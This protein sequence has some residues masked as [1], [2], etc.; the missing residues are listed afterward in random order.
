MRILEVEAAAREAWEA[1]SV[2]DRVDS[3][4]L[5]L[6]EQPGAGTL[7]RS[8]SWRTRYRNAAIASDVACALAITLAV[9]YYATGHM[10]LVAVI[11]VLAF[12]GTVALTGGYTVRHIWM[13]RREYRSIALGLVS[14]IA[15]AMVVS[16]LGVAPMPP[17]PVTLGAVGIAMS[18]GLLRTAQR[19]ILV[20]RRARGAHRSRAILVGPIEHTERMRRTVRAVRGVDLVGVC[21]PDRE[22]GTELA[23]GVPVLGTARE[24]TSLAESLGADV[25]MVSAG[26]MSPDEF[27]QFRWTME[28][29]G[30]EVVVV[31][32]VD[33][34]LG[35]RIDLQVID[36]TPM[37]TLTGPTGSQHVAK[38]MM[39]RVL[40]SLLLI[41]FGPVILAGAAAVKLTSAGPAIF[42][43]IRVGRD[44]R[45][46]TMLK[47]R[48]MRVD[49]ED[50]RATLLDR[51]EGAG[52]L[53]KM[54][55]DPRITRVGR[56]LRRFSLDE[57]PQLWNV[58]RGDMSLVGPRPPLQSEVATYDAMAVH[59]LHVRPGLT[60]LWQVS[61]RSDLTWEE[62]IRLDLRYVDNWSLLFDLQILWRTV[63]AVVG[64]HGAY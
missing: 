48:S 26:I 16:F 23:T 45:P 25:V 15:V 22:P 21:V 42:R 37:M 47:L 7:P 33:E 14:L 31:P 58:V 64:A 39:D 19:N 36:A 30:T 12:V 20:L 44:G 27:R 32:E 8:H 34:V 60:G 29:S 62:S 56:L 49:A 13:R 4:T 28:R 35:A 50:A 10:A 2:I 52:P 46:F 6:V 5:P 40:G 11:G 9:G 18:A 51:N 54:T 59:R 41:V 57:L 17:A 38:A 1:M 55:A 53:F 63:R 43:Q 3:V 61:G 24:A